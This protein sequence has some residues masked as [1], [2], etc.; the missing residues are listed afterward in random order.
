MAIS[1]PWP[2]LPATNGDNPQTG[3][4]LA[5]DGNFYGTTYYG[6]EYGHGAVYRVSHSGD[7]QLIFS[8]VGSSGEN[9][10]WST[11]LCQGKDGNLYGSTRFGGT[12][13]QGIVFKVVPGGSVTTLADL[14]ST[15]ARFP[16][17]GLVPS[18]NGLLYGTSSRGGDYD[19]GSIYAVDLLGNFTVFASFDGTNGS[20][21][22]SALIEASDGNFTARLTRQVYKMSRGGIITPVST[23]TEETE[24]NS[25]V[26]WSKA[27]T[28]IFMER[29][30][31]AERL[32]AAPFTS[33]PRPELSKL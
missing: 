31:T 32:T 2:T 5:R 29:P 21:P 8:F 20:G 22:E 30:M 23:F 14:G 9:P 27:L 4:V 1:Q 24:L 11:D 33:F 26:P 6:G 16:L 7:L 3:L 17:T 13:N 10:G 12:N 18:T 28:G 15:S 19:R 25:W